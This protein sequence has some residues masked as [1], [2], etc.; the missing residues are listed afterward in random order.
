MNPIIKCPNCNIYIEIVEMNCRQF[1]CGVIKDTWLQINPHE[2][3]QI[4]N[5]LK[6]KNL[7]YGCAK[8]III[9]HAGEV[10][11]RPHG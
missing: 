10:Q 9:T 7:I 1:V 4:C 11:L 3:E 5:E 2:S 8:A 6:D